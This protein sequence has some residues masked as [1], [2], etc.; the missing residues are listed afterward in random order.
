VAASLCVTSVDGHAHLTAG[1]SST[2]GIAWNPNPSTSLCGGQSPQPA[3]FVFPAGAV[4]GTTADG[5]K[6]LMDLSWQVIA[7]DGTGPV[8]VG[9]DQAGGTNFNTPATVIN[10][11]NNPTVAQHAL[12]FQIPNGITCTGPGNSCT[13]RV[14]GSNN[15]QSCIS[16]LTNNAGAST[17]SAPVEPQATCQK[18]NL[19]SGSFCMYVNN[20]ASV[21]VPLGTT[22]LQMDAAASTTFTATQANLKVFSSGLTDPTCAPLY[23]QYLCESIFFQAGCGAPGSTPSSNPALQVAS[24]CAN[25]CLTMQCICG[26]NRTHINL[27]PCPSSTGVVSQSGYNRCVVDSAIGGDTVDYSNSANVPPASSCNPGYLLENYLA[28]GNPS[29]TGSDGFS[30][31]AAPV[32]WAS[33]AA[34]V[35]ILRQ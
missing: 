23:H 19:P 4:V 15:W 9:V 13:L 28:G 7:G 12:A 26:L 17:G 8:T 35:I 11:D 3:L 5:S 25:L 10:T 14:I 29:L 16:F 6:N 33:V 20:L 18:A 2:V 21:F 34:A 31:L 30:L 1:T 24:P 32:V 22:I 27:Y